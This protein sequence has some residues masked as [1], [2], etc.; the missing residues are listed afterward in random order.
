MTAPAASV[1]TAAEEPPADPPVPGLT[2]E[3]A[4]TLFSGVADL[5]AE[6]RPGYPDEAFQHLARTL[7]LG[8]ATSVV[9]VGCGPG[10]VSLPLAALVGRVHAVDPNPEMLDALR[11]SAAAL[12]LANLDFHQGRAED[13]PDLLWRRRPVSA[14]IGMDGRNL[15]DWIQRAGH[16][17]ATLSTVRTLTDLSTRAARTARSVRRARIGLP[18]RCSS[19]CLTLLR[20]SGESVPCRPRQPVMLRAA[21]CVGWAVWDRGDRPVDHPIAH[22]SERPESPPPTARRR[23]TGAPQFRPDARPFPGQRLVGRTVSGA[24][25]GELGGGPPGPA[26]SNGSKVTVGRSANIRPLHSNLQS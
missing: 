1:P 11:R 8:P 5:Y 3:R 13:L 10:T 21:Y 6:H 26:R 20:L 12:G 23:P 15:P 9:D 16:T 2:P 4:R 19:S 18:G 14:E 22:P 24:L 25:G 17:G 7:R